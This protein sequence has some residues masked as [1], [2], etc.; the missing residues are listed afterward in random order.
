MS[1]RRHALGVSGLIRSVCQRLFSLVSLT[2]TL[3]LIAHIYHPRTGSIHAPFVSCSPFALILPTMSRSLETS[4]QEDKS[5]YKD[6]QSIAQREND[7][8]NV[9]TLDSRPTVAKPDGP[10]ITSKSKGVIGMELLASRLNTK[11]FVLLYG[12]F[13]LL[14]Y[15]LSLGELFPRPS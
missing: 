10:I 8:S 13:V 7:V 5:S 14:A 4:S 6:D 3:F 2:S 1:P 9:P 12:G 11:Y 15:T